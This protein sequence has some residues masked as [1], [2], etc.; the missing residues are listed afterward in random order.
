MITFISNSF[1]VMVL[2]STMVFKVFLVGPFLFCFH[3][4]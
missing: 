1:Y 3:L 4:L 2:F